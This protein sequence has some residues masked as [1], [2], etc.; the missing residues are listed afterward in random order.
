MSAETQETTKITPEALKNAQISLEDSNV[1]SPSSNEEE[2]EDSKGRKQKTK[3]SPNEDENLRQ[4]YKVN[5][6]KNWKKIS[7]ALPDRSETQCINR[8]Q[9]VLN[10][11]LHKGAWTKEEDDI[12][13][14]MVE[15]HGPKKWSVIASHLKGRIG[16]QCR[17]RWH[18]HLDPSINKDP[19]TAEE[20]QQII[21]AHAKFG[22]K[23]AE[24]AK[25]LPG[26]TDNM[27]KNRWNSTIKRKIQ[28]K[29]GT[30]AI[31]VSPAPSS[32]SATSETPSSLNTSASES[33]SEATPAPATKIPKK[34]RPQR[35]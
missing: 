28:S 15:K 29:A 31:S 5:Q 22:N 30:P 12:V 7:D 24:I 23:W 1:A 19:W 6:G 4:S 10:P 9:K 13:V 20:D 26:R 27:I 3:W 21:K 35:P 18:N 11:D 33:M 25:L 8:W 32:T 16:K 2:T 34:T 14:Q 17:E